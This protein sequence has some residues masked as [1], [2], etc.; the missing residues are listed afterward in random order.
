MSTSDQITWIKLKTWLVFYV[1]LTLTSQQNALFS[2]LGSDWFLLFLQPHLHTSTV[3]LGLVLLTQFLS[4]PSQQS[5]FRESVLP[6]TLIDSMEEPSAVT[7]TLTA[8]VLEHIWKCIYNCHQALLAIHLLLR[9]PLLPFTCF[10][11]FLWS[12][13][14]GLLW[15]YS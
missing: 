13:L 3:K 12:N 4:S 2:T 11:F 6:A 1:F 8:R 15:Q 14:I 7:G 5:S 10:F 9:N